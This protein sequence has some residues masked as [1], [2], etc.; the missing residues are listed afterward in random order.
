M[1]YFKPLSMIVFALVSEIS[2]YQV[3][4]GNK[5]QFLH[6]ASKRISKNNEFV[7]TGLEVSTHK[8]SGNLLVLISAQSTRL[9]NQQDFVLVYEVS[10][11]ENFKIS[12]SQKIIVSQPQITKILYN[13]NCGL[14][15]ACL[16]AYVEVFDC[17][18]F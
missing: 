5:K 9:T 1:K 18:K 13:Q 6:M 7:P 2:L 3:H 14:I 16:N 8:V 15:I 12:L 4:T 10:S 11:K 17:I